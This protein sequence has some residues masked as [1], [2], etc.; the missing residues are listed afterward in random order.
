MHANLSAVSLGNPAADGEAETRTAS[1]T[2]TG[3]ISTIKTFKDVR[4]IFGGYTDACIA[5]FGD[6]EAIVR[7]Q[8]QLDSPPISG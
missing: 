6:G 3:A 2:R 4:D 8:T 7:R 5:D 1:F